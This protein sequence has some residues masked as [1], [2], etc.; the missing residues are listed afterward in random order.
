MTEDI[1]SAFDTKETHILRIDRRL[2]KNTVFILIEDENTSQPT[3]K[4][5]N[6]SE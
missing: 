2:H 5:E 6:L 4:I 3:Y 1:L